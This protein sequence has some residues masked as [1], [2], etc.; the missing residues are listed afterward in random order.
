MNLHQ[1]KV[2]ITVIFDVEPAI[3]CK[4]LFRSWVE[5]LNRCENDFFS[6]IDHISHKNILLNF[7]PPVKT[8][9]LPARNFN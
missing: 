3:G 1:N 2:H 7:C 5:N 8:S 4:Q 9:C 6:L